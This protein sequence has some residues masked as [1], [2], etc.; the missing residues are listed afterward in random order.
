[1]PIQLLAGEHV[2]L[3]KAAGVPA[4]AAQ[5]R[6]P[7]EQVRARKPGEAGF[8]DASLADAVAV[9]NRYSRTPNVLQTHGAL[10]PLRISGFCRTGDGTRFS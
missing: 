7:I 4:S 2:R 9:K 8:D 6:P 5:D 10:P 3:V 1:M